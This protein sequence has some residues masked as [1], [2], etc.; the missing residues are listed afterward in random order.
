MDRQPDDDRDHG[1][2]GEQAPHAGHQRRDQHPLGRVAPPAARERRMTVR[3]AVFV[4][5]QPTTGGGAIASA[6]LK[7]SRR[8]RSAVFEKIVIPMFTIW[9]I[10]ESTIIAPKIP[11]AM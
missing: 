2:E 4:R 10:P 1:E 3:P 7:V 9:T 6:T 8:L 5:H 11:R